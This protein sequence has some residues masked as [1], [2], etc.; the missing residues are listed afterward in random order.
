MTAQATA[1]AL[2]ALAVLAGIAGIACTPPATPLPRACNGHVELCD[3]HFDEVTLAGAHNAMSSVHDAFAAPNQREDIPAQ[4]QLGIRAFLID[5]YSESDGLFLCHASCLLGKI[6]LV[7]ALHVYRQFLDG[8][9]NEVIGLMVEDYAT[10][11][12]LAAA[13]ADADLISDVVVHAPADPW[14]SLGELIDAHTRVFVTAEHSGPPPAFNQP[15]FEHYVDT[16]FTFAS[17]ADIEAPASCD[18]NRGD[19]SNPMML[20]NHW[21]ENP[22][23]DEA[24]AA[25]ANAHDALKARVDRCAVTR[26]H[27]PNVVAVDFVGTGDV[28]QVVD[29]LNGL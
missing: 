4:L 7:D 1:A 13:M 2:A 25:V 10:P 3:R 23:P 21:V 28:L 8:H 26:G 12:E 29:E 11:D 15:M 24:L 6:P 20:V 19:D 9:P 17:Q 18:K 14:P 22:I 16:P 5:S 27:R